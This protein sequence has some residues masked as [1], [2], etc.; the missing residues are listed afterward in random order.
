[1]LMGNVDTFMLSQHSDESVAA[2]GVANQVLNMVNIMFN[3]VAAGTAVLVAQYIGAGLIDQ[4]NR[5]AG[6]SIV[7]NIG[8]GIVL[9][10]VIVL[11]SEPA[12]RLIGIEE[13]LMPEAKSYLT[14]IGSFMF[15]EAL[16]LTI[17]AVLKSHGYTR[18]TMY[19]TIGMNI[20][21]VFGN[22]LCIFGPFGLPVL[23][24][25]GVAA[26]TVITRFIA[27]V[28]MSILL[29][30]KMKLPLS[31][32]V[33]RPVKEHVTGLLKIGV[34]SA[35]ENLSYNI[36]QLVV[37]SFIV[38]IGTTALVTRI[39]SMNL[40]FYIMLLSIAVGQG[41]QILVARMIGGGE[42]HQAYKRGLNSLY[43]GMSSSFVMA[44]VFNLIGE[45][46]LGLF[47]DDP[48][49]IS[50]GMSLLMLSLILEPGRAF[51]IILISSLRAVGDVQFPVYMAILSM[52][53][54]CVP[55]SYLL[56]IHY[57]MGLIGVFIAFILDEWLRGLCMLWRW[58]RRGWQNNA[59]IQRVRQAA[60]ASI[61]A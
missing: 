9:S 44:I 11:I 40:M 2:V 13:S 33:F 39:Y 5:S 55:V 50:L 19:I 45:P 8:I 53:G 30:R 21:N 56:G 25:P 51:N 38:S 12:L 37:T 16:L 10:G 49:V 59:T 61:E 47:T 52:W 48:S 43:I 27:L 6:T 3:F 24:V 26:V 58:R 42:I 7:L 28:V 60:S 20:I 34:P 46:L 23:G 31:R 14:I 57:G 32:H 36:S 41:T 18:D 15:L 54:I 22:Y 29:I 35:G 4:A 1:M 17:S